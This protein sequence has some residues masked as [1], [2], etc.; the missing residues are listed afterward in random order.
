M[1]H[2]TSTPVRLS[3]PVLLVIVAVAA[4]TGVPDGAADEER[5]E[6]GAA[7]SVAVGMW[8]ADDGWSIATGDRLGEGEAGPRRGESGVAEADVSLAGVRG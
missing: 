5:R 2:A 7:R 3:V 8:G 6:R 1:D 4:C